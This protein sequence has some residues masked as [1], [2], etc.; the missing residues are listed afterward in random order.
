VSRSK[1]KTISDRENFL[2]A[3]EYKYPEWIPI[4]V[5]LTP[6]VWEKYGEDLRD[7]FL[8]HPM[9]EGEVHQ[10]YGGKISDPIYIKGATFTDDWGCVWTNAHGGII[11]QVIEHPLSDWKALD[12]FQVPDL[13]NQYNWAELKK[14]TE[15][16]RREGKITLG[17]MLS[18]S[19][20]GF[21]DRLHMLRGYENLM[22]DFM[23]EPPQLSI[24]IDILLDYNIK[25]LEKWTEIGVDYIF[26]HFDI[27]SQHGLMISPE[28]F[29]KYLKP[30]Y[31]KMFPP[32]REAGV[33]IWKSSDGNILD[34]VD[35]FI[36]C[37]VSI[38]DPQVS[39]NTIDGIK[40][41][42]KGKLCACV[43]IDQQM[44][45]HCTPD[46]INQQ[47]KEIVEKISLSEGGLMLYVE[48]SRDVPL[49]NIEAILTAWEEHCFYNWN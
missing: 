44:L 13:N 38:H 48:P 29:R 36:E 45:P 43:D 12:N 40:D 42:Y 28:I 3:V 39:A 26:H 11:G 8:R 23:D 1:T 19:Q 22:M 31:L 16:Q 35:D 18:F 10:A 33:H 24:L 21:F 4:N 20:G 6:S 14:N 9:V 32:C 27:G 7:L 41:H 2:R 49:E 47:V 46:D 5:G 25:F 17:N 30:A 15:K 37:G 34:V